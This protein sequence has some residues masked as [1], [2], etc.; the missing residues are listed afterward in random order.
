MGEKIAGRYEVVRL[1]ARGGMG[2]VYEALQLPLRRPVALKILQPV[3]HDDSQSLASFEARF[4]REA[5]TLARLSHPNTVSLHD[6]GRTDS[7]LPYLVMELVEGR[8][9][10]EILHAQ[11]HLHWERAVRLLIQVCRAVRH[12]HRRGVIHRDLKPNNLLIRV[13]D[14][15]EE[16]VKVVDFGLVK[17]ANEHHTLTHEGM[18]MGSPHCMSPEQ[19]QGEALDHRTDIYALGVLLYK[20][21]T[22]EY[23]FD[24]PTATATMI[25]HVQQE[26]PPLAEALPPDAQVHPALDGIIRRCLAKAP[27]DRYPDVSELLRELSALVAEGRSEAA[28]G[29]SPS[30]GDTDSLAVLVDRTRWRLW[31]AIGVALGALM[32]GILAL[33]LL[34]TTP[35]PS[36]QVPGTSDPAGRS[37][38]LAG[39]TVSLGIE[40]SPPGARVL[41]GDQVLGT[42]PFTWT[43]D[44]SGPTDERTLT[45]QLDGFG[46][47]RVTR[48][49]LHLEA[50]T[51]Q[52][53]LSP[54]PRG[55]TPTE[56]P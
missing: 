17:L 32:V 4:N 35:A 16:V 56:E 20:C 52:V 26:V 12:A 24:G 38:I 30:P 47:V 43:T 8:S 34:R 45:F 14:D 37:Q 2:A 1:I 27:E 6:Y 46:D 41:F 33:V 39:P 15:G 44:T 36:T 3:S 5:E 25:A 11:G 55:P 19:V 49:L 18:V 48:D 23:P 51:I 9:L 42:T 28:P 21:L 53:V 13:Q 10:G 54:L 22:G 31:I 7:G 50:R 29:R 40:S